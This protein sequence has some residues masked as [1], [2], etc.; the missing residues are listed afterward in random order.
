MVRGARRPERRTSRSRRRPA[1][2]RPEPHPHTAR[3]RVIGGGDR[4]SPR[5]R[6]RGGDRAARPGRAAPRS[7][8]LNLPDEVVRYLTEGG[9]GGETTAENRRALDRWR[10][11]PRVL[12][13]VS[14][15]STTTRLLGD[16]AT[17]PL[18]IAPMA[19]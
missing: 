12:V 2:R 5:R 16:S 13:D 17:A 8:G 11:V 15:A 18:V 10:L 4:R 6:R 7:V 19:R 9:S 14:A 3:R 1:R